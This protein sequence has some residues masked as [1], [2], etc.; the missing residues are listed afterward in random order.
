MKSEKAIIS[1]LLQF[2]SS[3][4]MPPRG[5][6]WMARSNDASYA[7]PAH[8]LAFSHS[9]TCLVRFIKSVRVATPPCEEGR[10]KSHRQVIFLEKS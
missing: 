9:P 5:S 4:D 6:R 1:K 2:D 8:L 3:L 10:K 7:C